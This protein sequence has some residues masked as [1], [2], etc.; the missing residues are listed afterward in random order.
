MYRRLHERLK[1]L[2]LMKAVY[3]HHHSLHQGKSEFFRGAQVPAFERADRADHVLAEWQRR[4][5]GEVVAPKDHGLAP[6]LAVHSQRYIDFLQT[7]WSRWVALDPG[8]AQRDAFPSVWAIRTLRDDVLPHSFAAQLGLFS[9]D[10][11]TPLTAGS[12]Q[13]AK[14]GADCALTAADLVL[15]G[16]RTAFALTRPP[17][18][19]AGADFLGGYCFVN[20]AAVAAQH[21]RGK[22]A[23]RVA[24][25]D[26]DYHHGNGTQSIFYD[27]ADVL[28]VSIHGD[29]KTEF[30]FY[31]GHADETGAGAGA[32]CNLNLPLPAGTSAS[33]WFEALE[34]ALAKVRAF[35]PDVL[36]LS[37]GVDTFEGDPISHFKLTSDDYLRMSERLAA[38]GLPTVIVF[39][40]GYAIEEIGVNAANALM[41][42]A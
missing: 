32:G 35:A 28:Y 29:P 16:A 13:A 3:N 31:L 40:G 25:L 34:L 5:L 11:G 27:R 1:R 38:L 6:I 7:A 4:K 17:G 2:T 42:F 12:W 18:H 8:N 21:L 9:M 26:V 23:S 41:A 20:H 36:V 39:E 30:P 10:S 33:R 14:T 24:V 15:A 22:G 37:L 19:H